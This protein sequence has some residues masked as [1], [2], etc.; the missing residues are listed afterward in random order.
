MYSIQ[1]LHSVF[2]S[3]TVSA[4]RKDL[5]YRKNEMNHSVRV[6]CTPQH[7]LGGNFGRAGFYYPNPKLAL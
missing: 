2:V 5:H 7:L 1:L 4:V 6:P 3:S